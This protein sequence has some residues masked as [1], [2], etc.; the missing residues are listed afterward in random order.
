MLWSV[1]INTE[2]I[3]SIQRNGVT[4]SEAEKGDVYRTMVPYCLLLDNKQKLRTSVM[5]K[6]YYMY[7]HGYTTGLGLGS[8]VHNRGIVEAM[9][10][11]MSVTFNI[12][13]SCVDTVAA[14]ISKNKVKVSIV[15][16]RADFSTQRKAEKLDRAVYSLMFSGEFRQVSKDVFRDAEISGTGVAKVY[17]V[18][19]E[20]G[21]KV[22]YERV[23]PWEILVDETDAMYGS[24]TKLHQ[25]RIVSRAALAKLPRWTKEQVEIIKKA[26]QVDVGFNTTAVDSIVVYEG[27]DVSVGRHVMCL[28]SGDLVDETVEGLEFPFVFIRWT[29]PVTGFW[30]ISLVDEISTIQIEINKMLYF[31]SRAMQLGHAPKWFIPNTT[32]LPKQFLNNDIGQIIP[33]AG[34]QAPTYYTPTPISPQVIEYIQ[35]M[36]N[37]AYA[38]AGISQLSAQSV[39][40]AGLNAGVALQTYNDIESE[41]FILVGQEFENMYVEAFKKTIGAAKTISEVQPDFEIMG[42]TQATGLERIAWRDIDLDQDKYMVKPF[43]TSALP[44]T[45]E[46]RLQRLNDW[47]TMGIITQDEVIELADFPDLQEY[48]ESRY[49]P[50]VSAKNLVSKIIETGMLIMPSKFDDVRLCGKYAVQQ[51][52]NLRTRGAPEEVLFA[53]S[54]FIDAC[55]AMLPE[56]QEALAE[57]TPEQQPP[58]EAGLPAQ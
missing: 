7:S 15:T 18:I 12:S 38:I 39:K 37:Q 58:P 45:P 20:K 54:D 5:L 43:P 25:Y 16:D 28:D 42:G 41:R 56:A 11:N 23:L 53:L 6:N 46:G 2:T 30:G 57:P 24:P 40:P 13:K 9:N 47:M 35:F 52:L 10:R 22:K 17:P 19:K 32:K 44:S 51:Y 8:Y 29:K 49:A 4:W 31:T 3:T 21:S 34:S 48:R 55:L 50:S 36:T 1:G 27:W 14:K 26:S 33:L